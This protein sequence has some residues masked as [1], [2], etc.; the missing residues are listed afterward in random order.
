MN[1]RMSAL[2]IMDYAIR[3]TVSFMNSIL[4]KTTV[5][6]LNRNWWAINIRTPA[7]AFCQMATSV[8]TALEFPARSSFAR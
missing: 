8:A 7:E 4:N 2:P 3:I 6:V 1:A 5:L